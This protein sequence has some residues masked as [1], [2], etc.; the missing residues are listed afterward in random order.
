MHTASAMAIVALEIVEFGL[1]LAVGDNMSAAVGLLCLF[2]MG[3]GIKY[4]GEIGGD[5]VRDGSKAK[6]L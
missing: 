6:I 2:L 3:K 1:D 5:A 4:V